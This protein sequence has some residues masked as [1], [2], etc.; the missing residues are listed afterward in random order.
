MF[1]VHLDQVSVVRPWPSTVTVSNI[2]D[3]LS[4]TTFPSLVLSRMCASSF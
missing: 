3:T 1:M 2:V 4:V